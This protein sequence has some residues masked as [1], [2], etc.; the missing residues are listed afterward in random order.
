MLVAAVDVLF[1]TVARTGE[2]RWPSELSDTVR[3]EVFPLAIGASWLYDYTY[4]HKWYDPYGFPNSQGQTGTISFT[5]LTMNEEGSRKRWTVRERDNLHFTDTT[6]YPTHVYQDSMIVRDFTFPMY[7]GGDMLHHLKAD[8]CAI[9]WLSPPAQYYAG[10]GYHPDTTVLNRY[11]ADAR[12]TLVLRWDASGYAWSFVDSLVLVKDIGLVRYMR[13]NYQYS[14]R[15]S[16]ETYYWGTLLEHQTTYLTPQETFPARFELE[17]NYP[18]PFNPTTSIKY[19]IAGT[20]GLG[21]GASNTRIVIYDLLGREVAVL[22]D[23]P[24]APGSYQVLF[25]G[26]GLASGVY[27]YRLQAGTFNQTRS[28]VLLR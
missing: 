27:Y 14:N 11:V 12:D 18:N 9:L 24:K 16:D 22:V 21:L 2:R 4:Y 25:D 17:Q 3:T 26:S 7:E 28:F 10:Y 6:I 1:C 19:T 23:E 15:Y 5:V 20:G 8:S 13:Y